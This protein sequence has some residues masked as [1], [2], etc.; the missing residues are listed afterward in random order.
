MPNPAVTRYVVTGASGWIGRAALELLHDRLGPE[1][2]GR[3]VVAFGSAHRALTIHPGLTVVQHPL[4]DIAALPERDTI[5]LHA[6]FLTRDRAETM[7][8]A[9]YT[10][11]NRAIREA[12]LAAL[13]PIGVRAA[14]VPSSGAVYADGDG[15]LARYGA[16]KREDE[17][18]FAVAGPSVIP[19]VFNLSGRHINKP[20]HYALAS[21]ITDA[22]ARRA[23]AIRAA[24]PVVRSYVAVEELLSLTFAMADTGCMETF[25]TAGENTCELTELA[26]AVART[27]SAV[28][29]ERPPV[30]GI[31]DRYVGDRTRYAALLARHEIASTPLDQQIRI[32]ADWLAETASLA[33]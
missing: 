25:D 31:P 14:I 4:A 19:R 5:L 8:A 22:L 26:D 9:D 17:D 32:T 16:L 24:H 28:A 2:F 29:I 27:V 11:G 3:D 10:R 13:K 6:A 33:A 18:A 1:A 7:T 21:F 12:V 23:I 30:A 20:G 15:P